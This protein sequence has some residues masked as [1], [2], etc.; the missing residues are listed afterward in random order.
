MV[1]A[2]APDHAHEDVRASIVD[3]GTYVFV[4]I[5]IYIETYCIF[6][7]LC[8]LSPRQTNTQQTRDHVKS[9]SG[10]V[11]VYLYTIVV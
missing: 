9:A 7:C 2:N 1:N 3:I 10:C 4:Y 11:F 8:T 5:Y 6:L